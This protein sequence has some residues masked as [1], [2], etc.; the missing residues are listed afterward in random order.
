MKIRKSLGVLLS[1]GLAMTMITPCFA[2]EEIT[3]D[4][5]IERHHKKTEEASSISAEEN[6][7][8]S[9]KMA[10]F[11]EAM[12]MK[13][14]MHFDMENVDNVSHLTGEMSMVQEGTSEEDNAEEN[15]QTEMYSVK[16]ED[17]SYTVYTLDT[18]TGTW[19]K[20]VM[21]D[22]Q[23]NTD[24]SD[25]VKGD[26]F[27][28]SEE[29]VDVDG[30]ECYEVRTTMSLADM[31]EYLGNSMD[32]LEEILP[33]GGEADTEAYDL[34]VAYYFDVETQD[35][36]SMKMD[37]AEMMEKMFK[38]ALT[39]SFSAETGMT[40]EEPAFDVDA[41]MALFQIEIPEFTVEV[42]HIEF[43]TVES[44]E[45]PE[46]A[47]AAET[48]TDLPGDGPDEEGDRGNG[49]SGSTDDMITFE[50]MTAVDNENCSII[51][52]DIDPN[53]EWGYTIHA[54]LE[55]KSPDKKLMFSIEDAYVNEVENYPLFAAEVAPGKKA[56]ETIE[57][58]KM[59]EYGITDFSDI[60]MSFRVYDSEDWSADAV[61]EETVHVYPHGEDN[62]VQFEYEP[63]DT[64]QI[65]YDDDKCT[66]IAT[67]VREDDIWGYVVD[68][69]IDNKTDKNIVIDA[70]DVSV[71]GYMAEPYFA[72]ALPA[73]KS[74]FTEMSW[75]D[76][77]LEEN[78]ITEVEEIEFTLRVY[79][80][81]DWSGD[82]L[83]NQVI[84]YEVG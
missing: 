11:G 29:T 3:A 42:N 39:A 53:G 45:I 35:L 24:L 25:L 58:E 64:D 80:N 59:D 5:L 83:V 44:I 74:A 43:N 68:L 81:D 10:V 21:D 16:E 66:V 40:E 7:A 69:F 4:S 62:I 48:E 28:L 37:G 20:S 72:H 14:N 31:M 60:E 54:E 8:L 51:L 41:L 18:D 63:A 55:N 47:L 27:E 46:E 32:G 52:E 75:S 33:V 36:V 15:M 79:D 82:D 67:G 26:S 73:G 12:S 76:S 65:L 13:M 19:S 49:G 22:M 84:T 23:F 30:A 71:N 70:E 17:Q 1:I 34:D 78:G 2:E 6:F 61:A 77:D 56:K 57:F 50:G 38:E 9:M